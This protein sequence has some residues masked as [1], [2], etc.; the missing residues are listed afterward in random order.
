M[1]EV[2]IIPNTITRSCY[3]RY[4][5]SILPHVMKKQ[6]RDFLFRTKNSCLELFSQRN[7]NEIK[8]NAVHGTL[9]SVTAT[10]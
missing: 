4:F 3:L 6:E 5:Q 1:L 7:G 8:G 9:R 10:K 2:G